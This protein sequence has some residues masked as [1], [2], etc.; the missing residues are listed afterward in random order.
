MEVLPI[1]TERKNQYSVHLVLSNTN[2]TIIVS[3]RHGDIDVHSLFCSVIFSFSNSHFLSF[4]SPFFNIHVL[5]LKC[6]F[7]DLSIGHNFFTTFV[8]TSSK[9]PFLLRLKNLLQSSCNP[10]DMALLAN[11]LP[12]AHDAASIELLEMAPT[13]E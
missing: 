3:Y 6:S 9:G 4:C 10:E 5:L 13:T 8:S 7:L 11:F 2:F 1:V 12:H